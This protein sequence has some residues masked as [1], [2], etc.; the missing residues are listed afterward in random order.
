[1]SLLRSLTCLCLVALISSSCKREELILSDDKKNSG[2][3]LPAGPD[4]PIINGVILPSDGGT[5]IPVGGLGSSVYAIDENWTYQAVATMQ[6]FFNP[7][8][9][10]WGGSYDGSA[11]SMTALIDFMRISG[12]KDYLYVINKVFETN[13]AANNFISP[14]YDVNALWA[15][16]WIKAYDLIGDRRYLETAKLIADDLDANAWNSTCGGGIVTSKTTLLKHAVPNGLYIQLMT[17]LHNRISSDVRYIGLAAKGWGWVLTSGMINNQ[18]L[19]NNGLNDK[20]KN[21][22]LPTWSHAQ[23]IYLG[24]ALELFNAHAN[25]DYLEKAREIALASIKVLGVAGVLKEANDKACGPCV[26]NERAFK[27]MF[28]RNLRELHM[29]LKDP[30]IASFLEENVNAMWN[31]SRSSSDLLG[32]HWQG[33]FDSGDFARQT[34]GVELLNAAISTKNRGN[35]ALNRVAQISSSCAVSEGAVAAVDGSAATKWCA[36]IKPEGVSLVVDLGSERAVK[37]FKV[38]HAGAGGESLDYN[39]KNFEISTGNS[40]SGPWK[41]VVVAMDNTSSATFHKVDLKARYIRLHVSVGGSD[42]FARIYEF[43]AE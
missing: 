2:E 21:D 36:S 39:T 15:I 5:V 32:F 28:M 20:C 43:G 38:L 11:N 41:D 24:A 16:A 8:T 25:R 33:P 12:N 17:M 14:S 23:G 9:A 27:G 35:L 31:G 18:N 30:A 19:L 7:T 4:D 6:S 3:Q 34:S 10:L 22:G 37:L 42:G 13:K 1:M 29:V 40:A 26:S